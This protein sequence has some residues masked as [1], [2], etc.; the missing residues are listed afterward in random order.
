MAIK[1]SP[2][3]GLFRVVPI[4]FS[5]LW[6]GDLVSVIG[7]RSNTIAITYNRT[8]NFYIYVDNNFTMKHLIFY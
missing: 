5:L 3:S 7:E 6:N 2:C 4:V 8:Y 1:S